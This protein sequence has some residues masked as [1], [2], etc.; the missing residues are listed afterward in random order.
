MFSFWLRQFPDF[1]RPYIALFMPYKRRLERSKRVIAASV[2]PL[3]EQHSTRKTEEQASPESGRLVQWLVERYDPKESPQL[4]S[5]HIIKD[6]NT[7]CFAA[8]HGP[9]FLLIPALIDL[10]SYPQFVTP[11]RKEI[12]QELTSAPFEEWTRETAERL[13]FLDAFCKESSR[14]NPQ[15]LCKSSN[16][17]PQARYR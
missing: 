1:L 10:T 3:I 5:S 12:D 13:E 2:R 9:N 17:P 6:H 7:L 4:I 8:I 15:S 16:H 11:L 14:I